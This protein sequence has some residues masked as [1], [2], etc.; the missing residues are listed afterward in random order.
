MVFGF[1]Q[2]LTRQPHTFR[3]N[4]VF[5]RERNAAGTQKR[6]RAADQSR[7]TA[8]PIGRAALLP[9]DSM[10]HKCCTNKSAVSAFC[11]AGVCHRYR[12]NI[13]RTSF[14]LS[15]FSGLS[16][17]ILGFR[18][19]FF[20][21]R[22]GGKLNRLRHKHMRRRRPKICFPS[23]PCQAGTARENPC[24][25]TQKLPLKLGQPVW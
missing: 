9:N 22:C 5:R 24:R 18:K 2:V 16:T 15:Y 19:D 17:T 8:P 20:P 25:V 6:E 10:P 7:Q 3:M 1:L 13:H 4:C 23:L 12:W 21:R 14:I 11:T